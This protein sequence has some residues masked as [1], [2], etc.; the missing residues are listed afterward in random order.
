MSEQNSLEIVLKNLKPEVE[1]QSL[2]FK[3]YSEYKGIIRC[4]M[5]G[6][7]F[8]GEVKSF[9]EKFSAET[10]TNW[11][12]RRT[13]PNVQK[14]AFRKIFVCQHNNFNKNIQKR[15]SS[16]LRNRMKGCNAEIDI[17][18]KKITKATIRR[19]S[20]LKNGLNAQIVVS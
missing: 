12:V 18:I 9:I 11:I 5:I 13:F 1:I 17:K 19:D 6:S 7:D 3:S 8:A 2:E 4:R 14:L 20:Y 15:A 16:T 10:C